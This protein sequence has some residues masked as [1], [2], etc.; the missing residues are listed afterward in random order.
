MGGNDETWRLCATCGVENDTD[1]QVCAICADERQYVPRDGQRWTTLADR[2]AEGCSIEVS[3]VEPDCWALHATPRADIGQRAMLVRTPAGNLL[4]EVPGFLDA[5]ARRAVAGLGG[6]A[7]VM[8]SH[9]HMYGCQLEWGR[10]FGAPVYVAEAD[11]G[12]VRRWGREGEIVTWS[13]PFEV[14]PGV[15]ATQ[16]GGHFPGST[17]ALWQAGAEG[18]GVLLSGDTCKALPDA[19]W[20]SFMR[21]FPNLLPLS[22]AV[23][24]RVAASILELEFDRLYDN[25]GLQVAGD[26]R[27]VVL[28]SAQRYAEWVRGDHDDLT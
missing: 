28:R 14:L 13:E 15:L 24:E 18:R 5:D 2:A 8:S 27:R 23:V 20:V 7:A 9:P 19:G 6:V 3:E 11:R 26:A 10:A 25:F 22:A 21:S 17:V 16:P 4:W 12:W 1:E